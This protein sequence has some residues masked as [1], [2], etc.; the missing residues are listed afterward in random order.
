MDRYE[1]DWEQ[2]TDNEKLARLHKINLGNNNYGYVYKKA[3]GDIAELNQNEAA[4]LLGGKGT[5]IKI[6]GNKSA[7]KV[8][9]TER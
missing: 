7:K 6:S 8:E 2:L 1:K 4:R 5:V 3:N 9:E